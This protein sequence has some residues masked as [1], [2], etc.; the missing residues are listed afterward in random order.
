[1]KPNLIAGTLLM[2]LTTISLALSAQIPTDQD[3]LGAIP[4]CEGYYYQANSYSGT[5]NYPNEIPTSGGCPGNCL[6][7]GEKNCVWYYITVQS[8]GL[9]GF[10]ITPNN[11]NDDYDWAV[12]DLTDARCE[13]IFSQ[14]S[15]L[16]VSCNYSGTSGMTGPNG[17]S[18][19]SCVGAAGSPF[20]AMIP[21]Q[22]GEIYVINISNFSSSQSGYS[23]DFTMS[24]AQI[25]DDVPPE[26]DEIYDDEVVGCSTNEITFRWD[27]NVL[28]DRVTPPHFDITGPGG[29]Y[30][31]T[32]IVG[33]ACA[34]GGTWEKEY[35][36]FVDPPF[37][38]NGE[39]E[40]HIYALLFGIV[41]ACNNP[42]EAAVHPFTLDLGAPELDDNSIEITSATCG[43]EN[44][45]ITGITANGQTSLQY[46]WKNAYG[47]VVGNAIDLIDA[48][49]G[50]YTLEVHD[51]NECVTYGGPY[52][53]PEEGA[54]EINDEN[55]VI[56][57]SNYGASN[58]SITGIAVSSPVS[59]SEYIWVDGSSNIVG[60][61]LDLNNV[62]SGYY[63]LTIVDE[64]T[65]EA[66]AGPY[67]VSE[68]G[69]PLTTNPSASPNVICAGEQV[70]LS[71]GVGGGSGSYTYNWTSTPAGFSS[72][73]QNP[74]VV[75]MQ[76][77][78]YHL[79][80]FDGYIY[81][82]GDVEVNV[83]PL[84]LP[85]AGEDQTI[86]HGIYTT[87]EGSASLGSGDYSYYWAPVDMLE[88][89][90]AQNPQTRNLYETTPFYLTIVDEQTGCESGAPDEVV[91]EV[92]GSYLHANPSSPDSTYCIGEPIYLRANAGGGSSTYSFTWTDEGGNILS[93]EPEFSLVK[94]VAGDYTF[95][96]AVDDGYNQ[97]YGYVPITVK[98][99]P[100]I[101]LGGD[102]HYVCVHETITLDAG[103][104]GSAYL[105]SNGDTSK[106]VTLA[107]TGLGNDEQQVSVN[108]TNAEG[109]QGEAGV[110]IIF[111]YDYCVG[112]EEIGDGIKLKVF[113]NPTPGKLNISMSGVKSDLKLDV[114]NTIGSL[115]GEYD[116]FPDGN[117]MINEEIDLTG[118]VAGIYFLI[119]H[120]DDQTS[121]V[122]VL[123]K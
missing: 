88:D 118:Q 91:V 112:I 61:E 27:E 14:V 20:C 77:T 28:C 32:D 79:Q 69:G 17:G 98:P 48:P 7:S 42:A 26:V 35:T 107:T 60:S 55:I 40:L 18:G 119:F 52:E 5:G 39:Y 59:I 2:A 73:L 15:Q 108:V 106:T 54:P 76:T 53:I 37:A 100:E 30:T 113:P 102:I 70:L 75:P 33:V 24:T 38:S 89:A 25:Y 64:N 114:R 43:M 74:V 90:A 13:D 80:I 36:I 71:P 109:C 47:T 101:D 117:G 87:L 34:L 41:D 93:N 11:L 94:N 4:V 122:K 1:M 49:S 57:A 23:L 51:L 58:G 104:P 56:T 10:E 12:Y 97:A 50:N 67:F 103:N 92:T 16:Q 8:D 3:C 65:C 84:P 111:D 6:S 72:N 29:P 82:S 96:I 44:G 99:A 95:Y 21:V 66:Y 83:H 9:M 31:I 22:E 123:L 68:I 81:A 120:A 45:S 110:T 85:N 116:F 78:T 105:W 62:P 19:V 46:V 121:A 86:P 115:L 63:E